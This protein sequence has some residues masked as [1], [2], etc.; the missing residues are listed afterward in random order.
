[1]TKTQ[2]QIVNL[3]KN[4]STIKEIADA[5]FIQEKTVKFHLTSIFKHY[6]ITGSGKMLKL[7]KKV[8]LEQKAYCPM[9]SGIIQKRNSDYAVNKLNQAIDL[10]QKAK[11]SL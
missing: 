8:Y 7:Y 9:C 10:I 5:M 2:A 11:S 4:N 1:M 3:L 6:E